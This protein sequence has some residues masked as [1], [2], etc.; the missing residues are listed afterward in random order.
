MASYNGSH[1]IEV[2]ALVTR[3]HFMQHMDLLGN[4][5]ISDN[6]CYSIEP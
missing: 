5:A 4:A 2:E 1:V 6:T 3:P